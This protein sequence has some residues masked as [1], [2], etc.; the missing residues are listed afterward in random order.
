MFLRLFLGLCAVVITVLPVHAQQYQRVT[1]CGSI[2]VPTGTSPGY[3]DANGNICTS[4]SVT[5][6]PA[7]GT[8]TTA[9]VSC[10]TSTTV[11]LAAAAASKFVV[12][13]NP[14][15]SSAAVGINYTGGSATTAPPSTVLPVG[16]SQSWSDYIPTAQISCI[17]FGAATSISVTYK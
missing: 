12:I 8:P 13:Q 10:G 2:S 6:S 14:A 11:A 17:S 1:S 4:A 15:N 16:A 9:S 3:M 5:T 7:S